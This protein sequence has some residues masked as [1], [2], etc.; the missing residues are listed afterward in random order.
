MLAELKYCFECLV[1]HVPGRLGIA[2]RQAWY[3]GMLDATGKLHIG[4]GSKFI[5]TQS[6]RFGLNVSIGENCIFN[7]ELGRIQC[8]DHAS[9]NDRVILN[10][11]VGGS[12]VIGNNTLVGPGVMMFTANHVFMN[13]HRLIREQ[14]HITADV[15]IGED[16]W[17][18]AGAIILPGVRIGNGAVIG[19]GSVVTRDILPYA[20]AGGVPAAAIKPRQACND[21]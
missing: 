20:V 18:G 12:I 16:C 21:H 7:S 3:H 19:A 6:I 1:N 8:E 2:L 5:N 17:L 15:I 14:G 4:F 9:F 10:A 11:S 13:P